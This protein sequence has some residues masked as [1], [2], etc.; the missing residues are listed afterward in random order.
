[1]RE[2]RGL[3][4]HLVGKPEGKRQL[5]RPRRRSEINIKIDRMEVGRG[6][7]LD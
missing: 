2:M 4:R 6:L 5:G 7:G 3:F 1:M